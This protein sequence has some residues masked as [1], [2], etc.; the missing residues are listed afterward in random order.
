[1]VVVV[2]IASG[3]LLPRQRFRCCSPARAACDSALPTGPDLAH[4]HFHLCAYSL[5]ARNKTCDTDP[6]ETARD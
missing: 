3:L 1:M 4:F 5:R 2:L 6:Q